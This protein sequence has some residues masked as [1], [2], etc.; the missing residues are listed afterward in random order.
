MESEKY[1]PGVCNI[2][3]EERKMRKGAGWAGIVL[4]LVLAVLL[5]LTHAPH[6]YRFFLLIPALLA[7]TGWAQY[8]QHFCVNFGMRGLQNMDK[9]A[10]QTEKVLED[11]YRRK[12]RLKSLRLIALSVIASLAAT[13]AVYFL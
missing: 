12:D 9:A 3:P 4:F 13:L 5:Y 6:G 10:W 11:E 7:T 8:Q 1:I 2:G